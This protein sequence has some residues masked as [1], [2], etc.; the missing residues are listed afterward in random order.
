MAKLHLYYVINTSSELKYMF[1]DISDNQYEKQVEE[2][3]HILQFG[4][5]NE[6]EENEFIDK[7]NEIDIEETDSISINFNEN[8]NNFN[9]CFD[10]FNIELQQ[11]LEIDISVVIELHKSIIDHGE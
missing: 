11:T 2:A 6:L 5:E 10:F 1:N 8:L 3:I 9:N 4:E 7:D